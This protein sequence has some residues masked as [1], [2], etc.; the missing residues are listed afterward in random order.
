MV[1][2]DTRSTFAIGESARSS[3]GAVDV[4]LGKSA[5]DL[6]GPWRF[7]TGDNVGWAQSNFD[8]SQWQTVDFHV[9]DDPPNPDL[10]T[11]SFAP[12]W[13]ARGFP[14]YSGYAWYRIRLRVQG[15]DARLAI[16][17][18]DAFD[19]AYQVF[20]NG[21]QIG[22]FGHFGPY[23]EWA[24]PSQPR[25][26]S[27]P[28]EV[29]DGPVTI[30]I[31]MWMNSASRFSGPDAGG[32][33]GPPMIGSADTIGNQVSLDWV[34]LN[35]QVGSGFV[36]TLVL[37]LVLT[38]ATAHYVLDRS[39]RAYLWLAFV[40]LT[41]LMGNVILQLGNYTT[42]L[43]TTVVLLT[44][45]VVLAPL[46]IGLWVLFFAEWFHLG[47]PRRFVQL[48]CTLVGVLSLGTLLL[49]PP[50]H[51]QWVS[52]AAGSYLEPSL[53]W[54]KLTLA[55]ALFGVEF[56]GIRRQRAEGWFALP[57]IL[58]AVAANY[59]HEL[60]LAHV[61]VQYAI[62][63]YSLTLGQL[64]TIF[65][66]LLVTLMGSRRFLLSQR[67]KLQYQLEVEQASELQRVII[68]QNV[69][70]SPGLRIESEF[71]PSREVGGDFF[72]II[73]HPH[74]GSMLIVV[75]DVTGKG[76]RAGMLGAL[77]VGVIDT[78]A[79]EEPSPA[80][81][82]SILNQ[83][84]CNRGLATATCLIVK[85]NADWSMTLANAGH[86]PPY[87]NNQELE[88]GGALPL[89]TIP[90]LSYEIVESHLKEGDVLTLMTDGVVEA[91]N[92]RGELFGFDR[93]SQMISASAS[94]NAIANAVQKFGQEDDILVLRVQCGVL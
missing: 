34:G 12:G 85:I 40:S 91:Q 45:D 31:R 2:G 15:T 10:G 86:L 28:V 92:A 48:L 13:T 6:Y 14:S 49:R 62:L 42:L 35:H 74:D 55:G 58:L 27:L 66:L 25:G 79:F 87:V 50:L 18:P 11:S 88:M 16:K 1:A 83:C 37:L 89:G 41:T 47:V 22:Q 75:G 53:L 26:F 21:Q 23:H 94:A 33:H 72:Q 20:V 39:D 81:I 69:P 51:G 76:L 67:E 44:R 56:Q 70:Q 4:K 9:P 82:L 65:S 7:H 78:A 19:D 73:P 36:E 64:S 24:Y 38:V 63:G 30:A 3:D 8:D 5:L 46:R 60:R 61:R 29:Q 32:L 77:I 57:A 52:L 80:R 84:L 93:I 54:V 43:S 17:M 68:P 90:D 71:R 59:Q